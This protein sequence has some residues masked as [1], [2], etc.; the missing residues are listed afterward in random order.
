MDYNNSYET[1]YA[2]SDTR[3][4]SVMKRVYLIMTVGLALTGVLAYVCGNS[5][6]Y[7]QWFANNSW[8]FWV[9]AIGELAIV[10]GVSAGI[11][12]ISTATATALF[13]IFAALNGLMLAPIF[14][15]YT[16]VMIA[17]TFFITAGVFGAM[18]IYGYST[19]RDLSKFGSFLMMALFGLI[20]AM[21]VNIFL[22]SSTMD[23]IISIVG[24]L[25]FVGLTAWDTQQVK[26]IAAVAPQ[27]T[28][29]RL[30]VLGALNLYLDFINLFLY[31]LRIFG[32]SIRD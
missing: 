24:V 4:S 1:T 21:L 2:V 3:V 10:F 26:N 22:K 6:G 27:D 30:A 15:A 5:F 20:I 25:I 9:M 11:N 29:G 32:G 17:K 13:V 19:D 18:S 23:W 8:A 28:L 16:H 12:K 7:L 14:L 31:L